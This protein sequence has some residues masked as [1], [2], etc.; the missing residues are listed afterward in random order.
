MPRER[1]IHMID[2]TPLKIDDKTALG[3]RVGVA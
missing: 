1:A 3:L 2:V